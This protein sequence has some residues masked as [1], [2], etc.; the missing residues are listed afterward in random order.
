MFDPLTDNMLNDEVALWN[1]VDA[2]DGVMDAGDESINAVSG[3]GKDLVLFNERML[4]SRRS[5]R[6][7]AS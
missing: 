6:C 2:E 5:V 3:H 1:R 4:T 7:S